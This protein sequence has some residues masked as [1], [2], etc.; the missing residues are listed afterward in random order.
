M[1]PLKEPLSQPESKRLEKH[2]ESLPFPKEK[3]TEV[4][5]MLVLCCDHKCVILTEQ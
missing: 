1:L 3:P 4:K 2:L 5:Y